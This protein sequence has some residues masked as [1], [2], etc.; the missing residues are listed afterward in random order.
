MNVKKTKTDVG[1][2]FLDG[3]IFLI[4]AFAYTEG[5]L[6]SREHFIITIICAIILA[7]GYVYI[8]LRLFCG[9]KLIKE[10][11]T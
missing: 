1:Q 9:Y 11:S 4:M 6:Q 5:A 10:K 3:L 7:L 2:E 8:L